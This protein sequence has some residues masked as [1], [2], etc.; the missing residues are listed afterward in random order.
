M[1]DI[2]SFPLGNFR[3]SGLYGKVGLSVLV[4]VEQWKV[5]TQIQS[6]E[7]TLTQGS[8]LLSKSVEAWAE[9]RLDDQ[10]SYPWQAFSE[11]DPEVRE[12]SQSPEFSLLPEGPSLTVKNSTGTVRMTATMTANRTVRMRMSPLLW[13]L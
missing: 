9:P 1:Y 3:W 5:R 2:L 7:A 6:L 12:N 4:K 11:Q 8:H 13:Y 10:R